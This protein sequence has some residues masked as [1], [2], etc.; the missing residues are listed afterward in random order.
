MNEDQRR[1]VAVG[2]VH[3]CLEEL[4]ELLR[5]LEYHPE[6]D[7]LVLL[8][9]LVDRGPDSPGV[10]RFVRE[11]GVEC[12]KGNHDEK[13]PRWA[14][15]QANEKLTGKPNPMRR[16]DETR[17]AEWE[18]L[19]EDDL[20]WIDT[21]PW[22]VELAPG[23]VGVHAG[24]EPHLPMNKQKG[25]RMCRVRW[26]DQ[27]SGEMVPTKLGEIPPPTVVAWTTWSGDWKAP[28]NA[29]YGH[30][31]HDLKAP[32]IDQNNDGSSTFYGIDTGACFGGVLTAW[33][34][35][36]VANGKGGIIETVSVPAKAVYADLHRAA[37]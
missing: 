36:P 14:K 30:I 1:V 31:V 28:K 10:V 19:S 35:K 7:R 6:K 20:K 3:G 24:F 33:L 25:D 37:D 12:V 21:L 18:T 27:V 2:D 29:V 13:P 26:V 9:D 15:H 23:W 5:T 4:K 34:Y 32:K 8:G 17:V 16:P 22:T 11:L